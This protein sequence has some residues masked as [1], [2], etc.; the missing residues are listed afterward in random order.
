M[1]GGAGS[2]G[3][4]RPA[5]FSWNFRRKNGL[6]WATISLIAPE[7]F[8]C[9]RAGGVHSNS[10]RPDCLRSSSPWAELTIEP[11]SAVH[12]HGRDRYHG[13]ARF[14]GIQL[15]GWFQFRKTLFN[16]LSILFRTRIECVVVG[17]PAGKFVRGVPLL[18]NC[19]RS[20]NRFNNVQ[21]DLIYHSCYS[22]S[23]FWV[24]SPPSWM[25]MISS[26]SY[27]R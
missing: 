14:Q 8:S 18:V 12:D 17:I 11:S 1:M 4:V 22:K 24:G 25:C 6:P 27:V 26:G 23:F 20:I 7:R 13:E 5:C 9:G 3:V 15:S 16:V 19:H 10:R 21:L 2:R